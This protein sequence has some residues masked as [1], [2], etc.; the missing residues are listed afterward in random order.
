M[1]GLGN[2]LVSQ[3]GAWSEVLSHTSDF[4]SGVDGWEVFG[5][6]GAV[7]VTANVDGFGGEDNWLKIEFDDTQTDEVG[8]Q[9]N[10]YG[11][12]LEGDVTEMSFR[13]YLSEDWDGTDTVF[14]R[15]TVGAA[16]TGLH[17]IQQ[18]VIDTIPSSGVLSPRIFIHTATSTTAPKIYWNTAG[19]L[20][21][22]GAI[23]HIKDIIVKT[24][25]WN[26]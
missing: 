10:S 7:T 11:T 14:T 3:S 22:A 24:F 18:D 23:L 12:T 13:I 8:I 25:R 21:Q 4:T 5:E 26:G 2:S 20:P 19:D 9:L 16:N 1:L 15:Y 17:V 6:E